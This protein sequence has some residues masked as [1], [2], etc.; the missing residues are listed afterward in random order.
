MLSPKL[1]S[2][3]FPMKSAMK[4]GSGPPSIISEAVTEESGSSLGAHDSHKQKVRVSFSDEQ[5]GNQVVD[6]RTSASFR[7]WKG[8]DGWIF[9]TSRMLLL[10]EEHCRLL[11]RHLFREKYHLKFR[12]SYHRC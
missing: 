8:D 1:P 12:Q 2:H 4:G 9:E 5:E 10:W 11:H 6:E 7:C 3:L